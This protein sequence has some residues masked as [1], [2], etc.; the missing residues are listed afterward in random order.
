MINFRC[1]FETFQNENNK[2][3]FLELPLAYR[4][5][6]R[7]ELPRYM[8]NKLF[9]WQR[10]YK[11]RVSG[12]SSVNKNSQPMSQ[13]QAEIEL[14][15][16]EI[17]FEEFCCI[18]AELYMQSEQDNENSTETEDDKSLLL[19]SLVNR[20]P[21]FCVQKANGI[22]QTI[23]K[24][25]K[26]NNS[27]Q[28]VT[29]CEW[30]EEE[31][32]DED[33]DEPLRSRRANLNSSYSSQNNVRSFEPNANATKYSGSLLT[34]SH[35]MASLSGNTTQNSIGSRRSNSP[36]ANQS[37]GPASKSYQLSYQVRSHS[38][39]SL[40]PSQSKA[41]P[42]RTFSRA[43]HA[44]IAPYQP[45]STSV[46]PSHRRHR[47]SVPTAASSLLYESSYSDLF[48]GGDVES[49]LLNNTIIPMLK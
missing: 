44:S 9:E 32:S 47:E 20:I 46:W 12:Q 27:G 14:E 26:G 34:A 18:M 15:N 16:I 22:L 42:G 40:T 43:S 4:S 31:F 41:H 21:D 33:G 45:H 29:K 48:I 35:P 17:N 2:I 10:E 5:L 7:K 39:T 23:F 24:P 25:F 37:Q 13:Q 30:T 3:T 49:S 11:E 1:I 8:V 28:T 19:M 6:M 38:I 36:S